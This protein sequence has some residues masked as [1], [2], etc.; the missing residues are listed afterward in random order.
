MILVVVISF[1]LSSFMDEL[2]VISNLVNMH[3]NLI[4]VTLEYKKPPVSATLFIFNI[5]MFLSFEKK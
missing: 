3:M 1:L 2:E 5:I 4:R